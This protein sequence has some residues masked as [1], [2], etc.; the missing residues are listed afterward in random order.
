VVAAE[1]TMQ[2]VVAVAD[3]AQMIL[4]LLVLVQD[5]TQLLLVVVVKEV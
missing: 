4:Y 3:I 1:P 2:V 5:L